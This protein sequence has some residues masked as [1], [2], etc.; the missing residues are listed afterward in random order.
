MF[1]MN[2]LK[3]WNSFIRD[4]R[5]FFY[6]K[7]YTEVST[8]VLLPYPNLDPNI[9][10]IPLE[11][12]LPSGKRRFWLQTSPEPSMKKLLARFH[13]DIFQIAKVFRNGEGGR[14]HRVEFHMLE[15]YRIGA[16][17]RDL[18]EEIKELLER[19]LGFR[20]F[21]ER[22]FG[23]LFR[24]RTG[25]EL[26]EDREGMIRLLKDLRIDF[27]EDEDWETLFFRIFIEFERDLGKKVPLFLTHFPQRLCALAR[28]REG[29]AERFEL[30]IKGIEIANGWTEE[31]DPEE[32]G[33]RLREEARKRNL[34]IDEEFIRI[35]ENLPPCAGCSIGLDRLL[36]IKLGKESLKDIELFSD[37]SLS[38][39]S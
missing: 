13:T 18:I 1:K 5:E 32:V 24:Q 23:D 8:P 19:L 25:R 30:F 9:E 37:E 36:M 11:V 21:E 7:G 29:Y 27:K 33:R 26:P 16:T 4:V 6:E 14:I 31:T 10:P 15:W 28:V 34:P 38:G 2:L 12:R 39:L 3:E 35:H 17:Y 20:D 22:T